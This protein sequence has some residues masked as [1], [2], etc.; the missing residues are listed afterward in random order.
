MDTREELIHTLRR[1]GIPDGPVLDAIRAVRRDR[2]VPRSRVR[3]AWGNYPLSIGYGQTISQPYTVARMLLLAEVSRG[4]HLLEVGAGSGY[5]AALA[6]HI[7]GVKGAVW[8]VERIP[9]LA[10]RAREILSTAGY[11]AVRLRCDDGKLGWQEG[12]PFDCI[13]VSAQGERVPEKLVGQLDLGGRLV[14]PVA[15]EGGVA[16]MTKIEKTGV[17]LRRS[18]HGAYSFVRLV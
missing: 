8:A 11:T 16:R 3:D 5:V 10:A 14:M 15:E 12:A 4:S 7:V 17:G 6:A 13:I 1:E 9:E 2:F 18:V